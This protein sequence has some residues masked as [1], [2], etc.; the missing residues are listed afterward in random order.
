[1]M[2]ARPAAAPPQPRLA[3]PLPDAHALPP[4]DAHQAA[5][6]L[7]RLNAR[8]VECAVGDFT[9]IARGKLVALGDFLALGG[10]KLPS[11]VFGLT[12]TAGEPDTVF[13][14]LLPAD[15]SDVS[16]RPDLTTLVPRPDRP[17]EASVLCEPSGHWWS[18]A[19]QRQVDASELSPRA[20]LRRVLARC[21]A[22][23]LSA[24]VAPE[25]EFFLLH[26]EAHAGQIHLDSARATPHALARESACEAFSLER[27][28]HFEAY[29]DALYAA[30]DAQGI[31]LNGHGHESALSQFEVNFRP[32]EPLAQADAVFRFKRLARALA[33]RHG[34][35]A[36]F[37]PKPFLTQPG[38]GMHWHV[39]L[40]R[41][42]GPWRPV[43]A[44]ADGRDTAALGQF[45]AGLQAHAPA[46][47]AL[48]APH[49]MAYD[50]IRLSD[51]SPSHASWGSEDRALAFRIP[52]G[53]PAARRVENRLPGGDANPYLVLAA[54]LGLG[55]QGLAAGRAPDEGTSDAHA[56]P[57][58]LPDALRALH[59]SR[60]LREV[61][62]DALVEV[63][64][65]IKA[66]EHAE[67]AALAD[68]RTAWDL[69]HL[70]E[71]A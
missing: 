25:L 50:R 49:D 6:A 18:P 58:S 13:G 54:T 44:D 57:A 9:S 47:M 15:Y 32:G 34:F 52:A 28:A 69:R 46:A 24:T 20:A 4:I 14:R 51:A 1:M 43:F 70:I 17:H 23:G 22:A 48:F 66:H 71:L 5:A 55:L 30:C 33:S 19:L 42:E 31:A 37:A 38:V 53:G 36:S 67:R 59:A 63:Y 27:T 8:F 62:G 16:L 39:S 64:T 65:A 11:V 26:R 12:L 45:I 10:C 40:Q 35:L 60:V 21:A 61:L 29:F 56:L 2:A 3:M 7:D 41:T 68:P